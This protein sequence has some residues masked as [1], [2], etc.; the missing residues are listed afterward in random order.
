MFIFRPLGVETVQFTVFGRRAVHVSPEDFRIVAWVGEADP[1][2][3]FSYIQSSLQ[4]QGKAL[5]D[6]IAEKI[7]EG[8]PAYYFFEEP[9][10]FAFADIAGCGNVFQGK[11]SVVIVM[12]IA[13]YLFEAGNIPGACYVFAADEIVEFRK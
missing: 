8:G 2:G 6:A 13:Q 1:F 12:D 9:A 11:P 7:F 4:Q 10:A 3:N 5:L